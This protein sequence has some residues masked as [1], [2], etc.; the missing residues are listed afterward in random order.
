MKKGG[1][2]L[3]IFIGLTIWGMLVILNINSNLKSLDNSIE[4][5]NLS[6]EFAEEN[7]IQQNESKIENNCTAEF[8]ED[9]GVLIVKE[10]NC[11]FLYLYNASKDTWNFDTLKFT[12]SFYSRKQDV[13]DF[14]V[15]FPM[16]DMVGTSIS[17]S[18][19]RKETGI[20]LIQA[21]NSITE[22][23]KSIALM[24]SYSHR[25]NIFKSYD[26]EK[27]YDNDIMTFTMMTILHEIAHHWCCGIDVPSERI[28]DHIHWNFNLD[29]FGGDLLKGDIMGLYHWTLKD[30][31]R[32]CINVNEENVIRKFSDLDLYLM[33]L[34]SHSEVSPIYAHNYVKDGNELF[35]KYGPDCY[36][37]PN[38]N[39]PPNFT[40]IEEITIQDIIEE[41]GERL[42]SFKDS[43]KEFD[44]L[45]LIVMDENQ[46]IDEEFV[47]YVKEYKENLPEAWSKATDG[48][49]SI[50]VF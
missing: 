22:R 37:G 1:W 36:D 21:D 9:D 3:L 11:N 4:N 35:N 27:E 49:S 10:K 12:K 38:S 46:E 2:A 43:Q 16:K 31:E 33:G 47:N 45:F 50:N 25:F 17:L 42:P 48:K 44:V 5:Q 30:G 13:Y 23:L 24:G 39:G 41:N 8:I 19:N 15:V 14:L 18:V 40:T 20:N 26:A 34:I 7:I 28:N 6:K 29:L 32:V